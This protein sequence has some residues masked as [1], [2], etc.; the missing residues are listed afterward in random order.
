VEAHLLTNLRG[1]L[2][3]VCSLQFKISSF[4]RVYS[5]RIIMYLPG[6]WKVPRRR[7]SYR[8]MESFVL[9]FLHY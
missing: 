7:Q 9:W 8:M 2:E 3:A 5:T 1:T 4:W 6:D